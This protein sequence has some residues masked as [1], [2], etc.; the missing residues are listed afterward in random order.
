MEFADED[1][2]DT[3]LA[4]LLSTWI[5]HGLAG[6]VG[7]VVNGCELL[8]EDGAYAE[9][10]VALLMTSAT[11][12]ARRLTFFRAAFGRP[13][14]ASVAV[15]SLRALMDDYLVAV[16][17]P[18]AAL[19]LLWENDAAARIDPRAGQLVLVLGLLVAECL[20]GRGMVEMTIGEDAVVAVGSGRNARLDD[21]VA[22]ALTLAR[23][24][25][26]PRTVPG[27]FAARLTEALGGDILILHADGRVELSAGPIRVGRRQ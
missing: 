26:G 14:G 22:A 20:P 19:T 13:A 15:A 24:G 16:R 12:A 1:M 2:A 4:E 6:A 21:G 17:G 7:A 10:T 5:C 3:E 27:F 11:S 23:D 25:L 18:S 8:R 9:D